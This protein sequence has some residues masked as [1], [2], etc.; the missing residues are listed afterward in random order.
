MKEHLKSII[1]LTVI[2]A[3]IAILL[4]ATNS[5][6]APKIAQNENAAANEALLVVMP[7]AE[8]F[9]KIE[10]FSSYSLPET[11]KEVYKE[12]SGGYVLKLE[13]SGYSSGMILMV[14]VGA[15]GKVTGATCIA[16]SETLGY[17]KTYGETT[18]GQ[19]INTID[20]LDT[21]ATAT[22]TTAAYKAAVKDALGAA[23]LLGGGS[24]D[25][26]D[27]AQ[28]FNDNLSAALPSAEGKFSFQFVASPLKTPAVTSV[29]KA[30]NESGY[31]FVCGEEF[32]AVSST[33]EVKDGIDEGLKQGLI[34][35]ANL[36]KSETLTEIDTSK[37]ELPTQIE[38]VYKTSK[39]NLVFDLKASGYGIY[40]DKYTKS[41]EYIKIKLSV[42]D[43]YKVICCETISQ[44]ETQGVGDACADPEFFTQFVGKDETNYSEIDAIG[45]ATVTT[46]G[47][48]TA[49]LKALEAA[50]IIKG[51]A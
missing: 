11:V 47:Y 12:K 5:V 42:S 39:G 19:D 34:D 4:A 10:D 9:E 17:E 37:Y 2:C 14:G 26:R 29:Y 33:G 7:E 43:D 30:D 45:G 50:K 40:G 36:I 6:T 51:G 49:I 25:L 31:V 38:K 46:Q 15:D 18:K 21:I 1:S 24:V 16:S 3:V 28:I 48:T 20:S 22:K 32:Y 27:E 44:K 41:G 23:V 8:S 35:D 13:T